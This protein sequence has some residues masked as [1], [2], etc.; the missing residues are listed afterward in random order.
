MYVYIRHTISLLNLP[1]FLP[2]PRVSPVF[3]LS[4]KANPTC[5]N[6][7]LSPPQPSHA[8]IFCLRLLLDLPWITNR[9]HPGGITL[10]FSGWKIT[11]KT[12]P[13]VYI[14]VLIMFSNFWGGNWI[15]G[16]GI[17]SGVCYRKLRLTT[18]LFRSQ[19]KA[20]KVVELFREATLG[21][22]STNGTSGTFRPSWWFFFG[23]KKTA[24]N[25]WMWGGFWL[26]FGAYSSQS[27]GKG[28]GWGVICKKCHFILMILL[29][30]ASYTYFQSYWGGEKVTTKHLYLFPKNAE[31]SNSLHVSELF[32]TFWVFI[33][34][35]VL[36]EGSV[37]WLNKIVPNC[38]NSLID[39]NI[40]YDMISF[41]CTSSFLNS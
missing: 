27:V 24:D 36:I 3:S 7:F 28:H 9:F 25:M 2:I 1:R 23:E 17:F 14:W 39:K 8:R 16:A 18:F 21:Y 34:K 35:H 11:C 19:S 22:I 20:G 13:G 38:E 10:Q 26:V 31:K 12:H 30:A 6:S 33:F 4:N 41:S 29:I 37:Y 5:S 40:W 15:L 32:A